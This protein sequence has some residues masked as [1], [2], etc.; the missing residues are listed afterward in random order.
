MAI[1]GATAL[2]E[3]QHQGEETA[4]E[5]V[6]RWLLEQG[7]SDALTDECCA[8]CHVTGKGQGPAAKLGLGDVAFDAPDFWTEAVL[9]RWKKQ[10]EQVSQSWWLQAKLWAEWAA[11]KA[12]LYLVG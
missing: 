12:N 4:E 5:R 6:R 1:L 11:F 8:A 7:H 3:T 10:R 9:T 2:Q